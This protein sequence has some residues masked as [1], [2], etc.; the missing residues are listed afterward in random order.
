MADDKDNNASQPTI[1]VERPAAAE[2][3]P[4]TGSERLSRGVGDAALTGV[5]LAPNAGKAAEIA[6]ERV[7]AIAEQREFHEWKANKAAEKA[8]GKTIGQQI[9]EHK[10][11]IAKLEQQA[12]DAPVNPKP[13]A[14]TRSTLRTLATESAEKAGP[15]VLKFLSKAAMLWAPLEGIYAWG[16]NNAKDVSRAYA[17]TITV[18]GSIGV[19]TAVYVAGA[20]LVTAGTAP[21]WVP[22]A[23]TVAAVGTVIVAA[24][25]AYEGNWLGIKDG[26][27]VIGKMATETTVGKA[28][29]Q[30]KFGVKNFTQAVDYGY[31]ESG[32]KAGWEATTGAIG[33]AWNW[34]FEEK[35]AKVAA[36]PQTPRTGTVTTRDVGV[37]ESD[38]INR[39]EQALINTLEKKHKSLAKNASWLDEGQQAMVSTVGQV[40]DGIKNYAKTH[41]IKF[42]VTGKPLE[43]NIGSLLAGL[44]SEIASKIPGTPSP[45]GKAG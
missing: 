6:K 33:G 30:G 2:E 14:A 9:V 45:R 29:G 27:G 26:C 1:P 24:D 21:V 12:L 32:L 10:N 15:G 19:G 38:G 17:D 39:Q 13:P 43:N 28:I 8:A 20:T 11:A 37:V 22:A 16:D 35:P 4:A 3:K 42:D 25:F 34:A 44:P 41:D 7:T 18:L 31:R 23:L 36:A 40:I 5:G